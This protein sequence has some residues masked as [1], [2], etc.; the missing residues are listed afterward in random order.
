M[1]HVEIAAS[2]SRTGLRS[3]AAAARAEVSGIAS[4]PRKVSSQVSAHISA[5]GDD[6]APFQ[7]VVRIAQ[8]DTYESLMLLPRASFAEN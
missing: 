6:R 5:T 8:G 1:A 3:A 2:V 7:Q 4:P